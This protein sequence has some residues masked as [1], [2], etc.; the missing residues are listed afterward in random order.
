[1][2]SPAQAARPWAALRGSGASVCSCTA[3]LKL[4]SNAWDGGAAASCGVDP[5]QARAALVEGV[6]AAIKLAPQRGELSG[7]ERAALERIRASRY[8]DER[9]V[10]ELFG[11]Q[12]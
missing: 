7:L 10:R 12:P 6:A 2:T 11:A 1:M 4:A 5:A 3:S 8:G 9:S